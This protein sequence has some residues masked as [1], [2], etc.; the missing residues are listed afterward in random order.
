M[1]GFLFVCRVN[2]AIAWESGPTV[3]SFAL[4]GS[5]FILLQR[6]LLWHSKGIETWIFGK[7]QGKWSLAVFLYFPCWAGGFSVLHCRFCFWRGSKSCKSGFW[8]IVNIYSNMTHDQH[9]CNGDKLQ[10]WKPALHQNRGIGLFHL[11]LLWANLTPGSEPAGKP[12]R[13]N[14]P[15]T[16]IVRSFPLSWRTFYVLAPL[17]SRRALCSRHHS[18]IF[19]D[20]VVHHVFI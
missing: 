10:H 19:K 3:H 1:R 18:V 5:C 9:L 20:H 7:L 17:F 11:A 8:R 13:R 15:V 14:E 12:N 4:Q 16:V 6:Q 2:V